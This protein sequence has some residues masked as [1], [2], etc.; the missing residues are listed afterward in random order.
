MHAHVV[1]AE[2]PHSTLNGT[3]LYETYVA[4]Q[5]E[6]KCVRSYFN[7]VKYECQSLH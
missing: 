6:S 7:T 4:G 1:A 5:E 3:V 2:Y